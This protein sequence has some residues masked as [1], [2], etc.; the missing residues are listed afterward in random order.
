MTRVVVRDGEPLEK[1]EVVA[2]VRF[3]DGGLIHRL[4]T[5]NYEDVEIGMQAKVVFKPASE[6]KGSIQDISHFELV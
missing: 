5:Q 2:L 6:R 1:P 4:E 3:G